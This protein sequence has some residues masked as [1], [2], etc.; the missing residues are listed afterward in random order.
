MDADIYLEKLKTCSNCTDFNLIIFLF[1]QRK[2]IVTTI[3]YIIK[4]LSL[5]LCN[6]IEIFCKA[7][8]SFYANFRL[9]MYCNALYV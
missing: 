6:T 9:I 2:Y 7:F 8:F 5:I 3:V 4:F 1:I